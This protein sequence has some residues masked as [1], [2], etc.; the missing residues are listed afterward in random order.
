[1]A[2]IRYKGQIYSG[3]ASAVDANDVV[4]DNTESDLTE[5]NVQDV[6]D[7]VYSK[8][9]GPYLK[10]DDFVIQTYTEQYSVGPSVIDWS[11]YGAIMGYTA[12]SY[13]FFHNNCTVVKAGV[14]GVSLS[15]SSFSIGGFARTID[16]STQPTTNFSVQILWVKNV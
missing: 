15:N 1:M 12:K 6:I 9:A 8:T 7:E 13:T 5:G 10:T 4:Y 11:I 2:G 16:G 3:V 14:E